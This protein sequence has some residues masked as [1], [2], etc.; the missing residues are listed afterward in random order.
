MPHV[1]EIFDKN[2]ELK[3]Y[4]AIVETGTDKKRKRRTKTFSIEKE[5]ARK[6]KKKADIALAEMITD[7]EGGTMVDPSRISLGDY[8]DHWL[9]N[10]KKPNI[11]TTTYDGYKVKIN[12]HIKPTI[13]DIALQGLEPYHIE[14][15][16][17]SKRKNGNR[18]TEEGLSENTLKK[19]YVLLNSA[20]K[21]AIKLKLIKYNPMEAIEPPKPEKTEA[22]VMIKED[23]EKLLNILKEDLLMF[24]LIF[25]DLMTGMRRSEILGLE[26]PEV[27]LEKGIIDVKQALVA[28]SGGVEHKQ[29]TKNDT[30]RR[31]IKISKTLIDIL[32][33]FQLEQKKMKLKL[34]IQTKEKD[35]DYVFCK[36]DG[37]NYNPK[38]YT[39]KLN[40][41]LKKA[42]L[43]SKYT[44][45]TLRHT[46]ATINV[47]SGV[48]AE[49]VQKMLGHST[50]STT[51][52]IYYHHDIDQQDEALNALER[53]IN[54]D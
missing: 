4:K 11:Q 12:A 29:K 42:K 7:R 39:D 37:T 36:L 44:I 13:G 19:H 53:A 30:S 48:D 33:K 54:I 5:G 1:E 16:F 3:A 10:H 49:I 45:H 27:D 26:W 31:K 38:Y 22:P 32:K 46:F 25:T 15:Y 47:N 28:V 8:L 20:L 2:G 40:E 41:Y 50:I 9:E 21:R 23:Y 34:G 43:S 24:T 6:A 14:S 35:K 51:L 18:V 52:D 17:A